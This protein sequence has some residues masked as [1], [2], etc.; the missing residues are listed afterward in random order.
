MSRGPQTV[1]SWSTPLLWFSAVLGEVLAEP[2]EM[3]LPCAAPFG[4]PP[5]GPCQGRRLDSARTGPALLLR[6]DEPARLQYL[7]VLDHRRKRDGERSG[8]LA[9]R[10]RPH[11]QLLHHDPSVRIRERLEHPIEGDSS[12]KHLLEHKDGS[13]IGQAAALRLSA[14]HPHRRLRPA[15]D[16][17]TGIVLAPGSHRFGPC[18]P[19]RTRRG[20]SLVTVTRSCSARTLT[21]RPAKRKVRPSAVHVCGRQGSMERTRPSAPSP[22]KPKARAC[23]TPPNVAMCSPNAVVPVR[24]SKSRRAARRNI[25]RARSGSPA[26]ARSDAETAGDSELPWEVRGS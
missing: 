26:R 14:G 8:E 17:S 20:A 24:S 16:G 11:A 10:G 22:R 7:Y 12:V 13:A 4:N 18:P 6:A 21:R 3:A 2:V 9:D 1:R 25:A 23:H 19:T 5:L 15:A